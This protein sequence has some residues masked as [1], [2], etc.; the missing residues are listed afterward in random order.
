[1]FLFC[2]KNRIVPFIPSSKYFT[3]LPIMCFP[4]SQYTL[5]TANQCTK[6]SVRAGRHLLFVGGLVRRI[7]CAAGE[8]QPRTTSIPVFLSHRPFT[9]PPPCVSWPWI[10]TRS[11]CPS[12]ASTMSRAWLWRARAQALRLA[13]PS[14]RPPPPAVPAQLSSTRPTPWSR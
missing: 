13:A 9:P 5:Q 2:F 7:H 12:L 14:P 8:T 1:M 4:W 6:K 10:G 3:P 11:C